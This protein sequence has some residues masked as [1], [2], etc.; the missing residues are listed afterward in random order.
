MEST[1][2]RVIT[3]RINGYPINIYPDS[4][5]KLPDHTRLES[6]PVVKEILADEACHT[7]FQIGKELRLTPNGEHIGI[8]SKLHLNRKRTYATI[9]AAYSTIVI[10]Y[11]GMR[12][13]A[14]LNGVTEQFTYEDARELSRRMR[15]R[16]ED[17]FD[18][19]RV[20]VSFS[21]GLF[22]EF[23]RVDDQMVRAT[24]LTGLGVT[25]SITADTMQGYLWK[26]AALKRIY[27]DPLAIHLYTNY[28]NL[29]DGAD[30]TREE[31]NHTNL[32]NNYGKYWKEPNAP[33]ETF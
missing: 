11:E 21:E 30:I 10:A 13:V 14:G 20:L 3:T 17:P 33:L 28:L 31:I 29:F 32:G 24:A 6:E 9:R 15:F 7:L 8:A 25:R 16:R 19:S 12:I 23:G 1:E 26:Q 4:K 22:P 18:M 27:K 2:S 5:A